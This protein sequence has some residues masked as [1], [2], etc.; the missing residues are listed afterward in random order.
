MC[1][2]WS[3]KSAAPSSAVFSSSSCPST[4]QLNIVCA[5][6]TD[7]DDA[8]PW[9]AVRSS[10]V[11]CAPL[12]LHVQLFL[13]C[14]ISRCN[15]FNCSSRNCSLFYSDTMSYRESLLYF[16]A[17]VTWCYWDI[18][19]TV[20]L[21]PYS[22]NNSLIAISFSTIYC[23]SCSTF[24]AGATASSAY[25]SWFSLCPKFGRFTLIE[26]IGAEKCGDCIFF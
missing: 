17:A 3:E 25:T 12:V 2:R 10:V 1:A 19:I 4:A 14:S 15:A 16:S 20:N 21:S 6:S 24:T 7:E 26:F 9:S 11:P 22:L 23:L 18:S 8:D 13:S 5:S